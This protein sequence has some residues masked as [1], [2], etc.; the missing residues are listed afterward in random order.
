MRKM[1]L[2]VVLLISL[3]ALPGVCWG[4]AYML[5][6]LESDADFNAWIPDGF[7]SNCPYPCTPLPATLTRVAEHATEGSYSCQIDAN[8][9][10]HMGMDRETFPIN[11]WSGYNTLLFDLEN[12]TSNALN[13][14]IQISDAVH[15]GAW[16]KRYL[17]DGALIPGV[18]RVKIKLVNMTLNDGSANL[19]TSQ[20]ANFSLGVW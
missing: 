17:W 4:A 14:H 9:G 19:D 18:N 5:S 1:W 12:P 3:A 11:D 16:A 10:E 6:D 13:L 20:I 7:I 8:E 15:G 2:V